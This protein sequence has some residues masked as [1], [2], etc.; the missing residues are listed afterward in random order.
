MPGPDHTPWS[1][2]RKA[3]AGLD[4]DREDF[5]RVYEPVVRA[6]LEARWRHSSLLGEVDDAVQD[7]FLQCFR[8]G[9]ALMRAERGRP[10]GFRGFLFGVTRNIA[11]DHER[12]AARRKVHPDL[13][14]RDFD[15]FPADD[16]RISTILDRAWA[17][18][19]VREAAALQ[20]EWAREKG[21]E[22]ER[23]VEL[24]RLR[25][26]EGL[27]VREIAARWDMEATRVHGEYARARE[28]FREAFHEVVAFHH[29][30]TKG[31]VE[32]EC[33]RLVGILGG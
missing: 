11:Q 5:A 15:D 17:E 24:L 33:A 13:P 10:G 30:G 2:I 4:P 9:G 14:G 25:F 21:A 26:E 31:E 19:L 6:V 18:S 29:P 3:A 1:V 22:A 28:E 27:P 20:R 7:V 8:E 32:R 12:K 16:E 23:R